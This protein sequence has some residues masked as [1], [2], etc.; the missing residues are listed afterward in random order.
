MEKEKNG[1]IS[2]IKYLEKNYSS[3]D[4]LDEEYEELR[5][6][7]V[8]TVKKLDEELKIFSGKE[9]EDPTL[10][11]TYKQGYDIVRIIFS[12]I[13]GAFIFVII[14]IPFIAFISGGSNEIINKLAPIISFIG[15]LI[16][17]FLAVDHR[18]SF[19]SISSDGKYIAATYAKGS[20]YDDALIFNKDGKLL[21]WDDVYRTSISHSSD[22]SSIA[23]GTQN[24]LKLFD[25]NGKLLCKY[26]RQGFVQC[27]SISSDGSFIAAVFN[28]GGEE[29]D[30]NK[31]FLFDRQG[32]SLWDYDI[33]SL[34]ETVVSIP[35]DGSFVAVISGNDIYLFDRQG[36]VLW[37]H[38]T[39]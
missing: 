33:I 10:L 20:F 15:A 29:C 9:S 25:I 37:K 30:K 28:L 13:F 38:K 21:W 4:L 7:L 12:M 16:G 24:N 6:P 18:I 23:I 2:K 27:I 17:A 34:K 19:T 36:R 14:I 39:D 26:M 32:T 8:D 35:S 11:W 5:K 22:G 1:V 3:G 31:I